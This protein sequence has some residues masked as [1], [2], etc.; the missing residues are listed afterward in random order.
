MACM[1]QVFRVCP[2]TP[3]TWGVWNT[4]GMSRAD[5]A[6][7]N[8]FLYPTNFVHPYKPRS[9]LAFYL[10]HLETTEQNF[11][12][13]FGIIHYTI[14]LV[15]IHAI[16]VQHFRCWLCIN[17]KDA[18]SSLLHCYGYCSVVTESGYSVITLTF[19]SWIYVKV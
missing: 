10:L 4:L 16:L 19:F 1:F 17:Y 8:Y 7:V 15:S 18:I 5:L 6:L 14:S 11:M 12:K 3:L 2:N 9:C 13:V